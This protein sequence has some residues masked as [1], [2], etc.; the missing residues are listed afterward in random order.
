MPQAQLHTFFSVNEGSG[1]HLLNNSNHGCRPTSRKRWTISW[2]QRW[3]IIKRSNSKTSLLSGCRSQSRL[4]AS[5]GS[6]YSNLAGT[7]CNIILWNKTSLNWIPADA[8]AICVKISEE[9]R[10]FYSPQERTWR[11]LGRLEKMSQTTKWWWWSVEVP[12]FWRDFLHNVYGWTKKKKKA[13]VFWM[14]QKIRRIKVWLDQVTL[15]E[16]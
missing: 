13:L 3:D 14:P 10:R 11:I 2:E 12:I 8:S 9:R 6:S 15:D 16:E 7:F 4:C 1:S 5:L